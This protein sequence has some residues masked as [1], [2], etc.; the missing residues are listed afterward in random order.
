MARL[1]YAPTDGADIQDLVGDI[2]AQRGEVLHLYQ[3][4]LHSP[5]I[6]AGWLRMMTAVRHETS[7]PGALRELVIIR[8][9]YLN[10]AP[11]EAEQHRPIALREGCSE[12]QVDAL[13]D[14]RLH[15]ELFDERQQA[16]L[17]LTD[18][19]T[20]DVHADDATWQT[21]RAH[22]NE[23][24]LVELV[25]TIASYNMVSRVIGTLAIHSEDQRP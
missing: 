20:R 8:I 2:V 5:P 3:M 12:A 19:M 13:R 24:E 21:A 17:A 16:T 23:R 1:P 18:T 7:L 9:G 6:T 4:L 10:D 14:W 25:V 15:G 11:Y 22:W